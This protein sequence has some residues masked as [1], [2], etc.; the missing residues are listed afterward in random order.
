MV[1]DTQIEGEDDEEGG[2]QVDSGN[3]NESGVKRISPEDVVKTEYCIASSSMIMDVLTVRALK[4]AD[5]LFQ[6]HE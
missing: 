4:I 6:H 3:M 2:E 5:L 1:Y